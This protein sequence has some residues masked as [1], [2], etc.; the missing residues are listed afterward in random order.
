M[1]NNHKEDEWRSVDGI[2]TFTH[3]FDNNNVIKFQFIK[4]PDPFTGNMENFIRFFDTS[5]GINEL[6]FLP[7]GGRNDSLFAEKIIKSAVSDLDK[8]YAPDKGISIFDISNALMP[9][10]KEREVFINNKTENNPEIK[11]ESFIKKI[12]N[13]ISDSESVSSRKIPPP[14]S[15]IE[16]AKKIGYIQGVCECVLALGR[17]YTLGKKLL[18][19]MKV[20]PEMAKKYA[21]PETYKELEKGIFAQKEQKLEQTQTF[22]R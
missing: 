7:G 5:G 19:E 10:L 18:H 22:R 8:T 9:R 3:S 13:K 11:K 17:N 15:Q 6:R 21:S 2:K 12:S 14:E 16:T 4:K 1:D 20:T